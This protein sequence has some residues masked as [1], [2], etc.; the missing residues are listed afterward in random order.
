MPRKTFEINL[1]EIIEKAGKSGEL[2]K[3]EEEFYFFTRLVATNF[4]LKTSLEDIAT[5]TDQKKKIVRDLVPRET[6]DLFFEIIDALIEAEK[7]GELYQFSSQLSVK[8]A[9]KQNI[10]LG[11]LLTAHPITRELLKQIE[12]KIGGLSGQPV[13]LKNFVDPDLL[14]GL[15]I[16]LKSGK[17]IDTSVKQKLEELKNYLKGD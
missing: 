11:E 12:A 14:G 3:L 13:R 8:I 6:T 15:V 2:E 1:D 17:I 9:V 5:H 7:I 10:T 4:E 16:K